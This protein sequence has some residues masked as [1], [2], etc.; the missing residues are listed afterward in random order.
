M[1]SW[2]SLSRV[3]TVCGSGQPCSAAP[4]PAA[5][6]AGR[7]AQASAVTP[8]RCR[9]S[10]SS[11]RP[12]LAARSSSGSATPWLAS[13]ARAASGAGSARRSAWQRL[14]TVGKRRLGSAA[15]STRRVPAGG[16]SSVFSKALAACTLSASPGV[17]TTTLPRPRPEVLNT[18][19]TMPRTS[20]T[21]IWRLG[22]LLLLSLAALSPGSGQSSSS[23]CSSGAS[24]SRSG[25][26]WACTRRQAAQRPQARRGGS[27]AAAA[28]H[29]HDCA[30]ARPNSR[31]PLPAAPCSKSA[32]PRLRARACCSGAANQGSAGWPSSPISTGRCSRAAPARPAP[33]P[34]PRP[35]RLGRR[36]ARSVAGRR[37]GAGRSRR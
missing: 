24:S 14:R 2:H 12:L 10:A 27:L 18:H 1:A 8:A 11:G 6:A 28:S 37:P 23:R 30:S 5:S 22:F 4:C 16:S 3:S 13:Q 25:C 33:A 21:R 31:A 34:T 35:C 19:S 36:C 26:T 20:S 7:R 29:N 9:A 32:W 15:L 17:I